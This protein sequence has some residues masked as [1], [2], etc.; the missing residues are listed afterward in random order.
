MFF[1]VT[2]G[3]D[4]KRWGDL[5]HHTFFQTSDWIRSMASRLPGEVYTFTLS[6]EVGLVGVVVNDN[7]AYEA[8]NPHAILWR[9]EPVF[10]PINSDARRQFL[11]NL[12]GKPI[13]LPALV[14]V[15]PGYEGNLAGKSHQNQLVVNNFIGAITTWAKYK[16]LKGVHSLYTNQKTLQNAFEILGGRTY[17]LTTRSVLRVTWENWDDY[18]QHLSSNRRAK[19]RK[20]YKSISSCMNLIEVD[21]KYYIDDI[22]CGR[23]ATLRR[24]GNHASTTN[25]KKRLSSLIEEYGNDLKVFGAVYNNKLIASSVCVMADKLL[26]VI[27]NG[28]SDF[29]RNIRYSH[30]ASN[31][32][33]I[34]QN[35]DVNNVS[36]IDYGISHK[37]VKELRGCE[38]SMLKGHLLH[39]EESK[40]HQ[41]YAMA[42]IMAGQISHK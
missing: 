7:E 38:S 40:K 37:D 9:D 33:S 26:I 29:G 2:Q 17:S 21:A 14:L 10:D 16:N 22:V 13:T 34:I 28:V 32:Y 19:I 4:E 6:N 15:Y 42:E 18:L 24:Y 25:E 35:V 12:Q 39:F 27:Y 3:F 41:H 30:F 11:S 20:E 31:Y 1:N 36:V 5:Q 23:C 8:Y